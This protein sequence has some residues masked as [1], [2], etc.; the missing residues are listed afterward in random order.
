MKKIQLGAAPVQVCQMPLGAMWFGTTISPQQ[1]FSLTDLYR[2]CGGD[3]LDT[4]N[5]YS[6]WAGPQYAGGE[7]E[8]VLGDYIQARRCRGD[9][10]VA[11]KMGFPKGGG[12]G[13]GL[14]AQ[15]IR[16]NIEISL[17]NLQTDYVDLLYMHCDDLNVAMQESFGTFDQLVREGK[18]RYIGVS[19]FMSYRLADAL[20]LTSQNGW[21]VPCA[22]QSRF[23]YYLPQDGRRMGNQRMLA[24]EHL[25]QCQ[26]KNVLPVGYSVLLSGAYALARGELPAGYQ[27]QRNLA[28]QAALYDLAA[29]KGVLPGQLVLAWAL[30]KGVSPLISSSDESRLREN[31]AA[32][33]IVLSSRE[34]DLLDRAGALA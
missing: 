1:A 5:N 23:S 11:T 10:F 8:R 18:V 9:V 25:H 14:S 27:T 22:L 28:R 24:P 26:T 16:E 15:T 32:A 4:A 29:Q 30:E 12:K 2:S 34:M 31:M 7:S 21:A 19:N 3:F 13:A 6:H 33:D 20:T 17:R